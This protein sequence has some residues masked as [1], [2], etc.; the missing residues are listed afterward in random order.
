MNA[1]E[2]TTLLQGSNKKKK[3]HQ[4]LSQVLNYNKK[5]I[6][7]MTCFIVI[8]IMTFFIQMSDGSP[9]YHHNNTLHT[10][11]K[12]NV[13]FFVTD[14]MGPASLS[15]T[16]SFRQFTDGLAINDTLNLDK[17]LIGSSRTRSSD[18]LVTDSAAGATAFSC[19]LKT[20]NSAIG[21]NPYKQPCGTILEAAKLDGYLTGLVVTTRI[22]DATPAAFS[23]HT[24]F[25]VQEDLI[26][27]HQIG[28]YPLGPVVDLMIGGGR[29]HFYPKSDSKHKYG[30][31][32]TRQDGRNLIDEVKSDG[33][34]YVGNRNEFDQLQMG[35][36]V[37]LPLLALM[38]DFDIP[39]EIDRDNS[40]HPSLE[41]QTVTALNALNEASK[42]SDQG[43]FL[44]VEGS[45]IDHAGHQNDPAAQVR[46]VLAFDKAFKAA[47]D[48][49]DNTDVETILISTSDHETGG[50]TVARQVTEEYPEYVWLPQ[51]LANSSHSGEYIKNKI[52]NF[53]H[54]LNE[55]DTEEN[56]KHKI[57]FIKKEILEKNLGILDY[58]R[59]DVEYL[60]N[61][62][63][64]DMI[65]NKINDMISFRAQIGW[66]THGHSGVDVNIYAYSNKNTAWYDILDHLQ[67]NHE[68]IEIGQYMSRYLN[69]DLGKVTSMINE[70]E[71]SPEL[72]VKDLEK[73]MIYD[74][75]H[76][77]LI[78]NN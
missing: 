2:N 25:R 27:L 15:L 26:A 44:L 30:T 50:L 53:S 13:I 59:E 75:Y 69:L 24:D 73:G 7:A 62:K 70:T 4:S 32:G 41:E 65:Q 38:A 37:T 35:Q 12:R 66:T 54:T 8:L 45:R 71:H 3:F 55:D 29:T 17:H 18:S 46:E 51:V 9:F 16:R 39:F 5:K 40:I 20:Y 56:I 68:N 28:E 77:K 47:M 63:T 76:H 1:N 67:G 11:R 57:K 48:F 43:F 23:A 33:W 64:P 10:N 52:I 58:T 34:Q 42:E 49:A 74:D 31:H 19:A 72:N 6:V 78:N 21:V 36:N 60:A 22:T 14:G 61:A